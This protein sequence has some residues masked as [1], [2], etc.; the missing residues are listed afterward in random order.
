M[1]QA[2][3]SDA[4][5]T[6]LSHV[7]VQGAIEDYSSYFDRE[8][9]SVAERKDGYETLVNHFYDLVTDFYEYGWGPC[10]HFAARRKHES[11]EQSIAR[12]E[13]YL[14]LQLGL[15]PGMSA[16][17]LGCGV[18][19]PMRNIAAFCGAT[20]LGV[21]NNAYQIE[22]GE[23]YNAEAG[24]T[25]LCSFLKADFMKLALEHNSYDAA[26]AIEA[27][28][29]APDKQAVFREIHRVLKP[30]APFASYEWCVT[31]AFDRQNS[32][33]RD[34]IHTIEKG[35]ALPEL[36]QTWKVDEALRD[37]GFEM[38]HARD[39]A[40]DS[41]LETPWYLPLTGRELTLRG[42]PRTSLG[43]QL[44]HRAVQLM[45]WMRIAPR[46]ATAVSQLLNE[47]ADALVRGGELGIFTPMYL[48]V[49]R[50]RA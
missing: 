17:D 21:N 11:F 29:H 40:F 20:I 42:L 6:G 46:G 25:H 12:H 35:D 2:T 1:T 15:A 43:R 30:G 9:T 49:A 4:A 5:R 23:G 31:E 44:T 8:K 45:E 16:L 50:K 18:G 34:V 26:Y 38:V 13:Y 39:L 41:D 7:H 37:V 33:H 10:F 14:A 22:K 19:G 32:E 24:L 27:L 48:V 28:C 3:L 47:A 36:I